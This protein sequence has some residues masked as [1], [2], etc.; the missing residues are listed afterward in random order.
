VQWVGLLPKEY[1]LATVYTAAVCTQTEQPQAA[2]MLIDM[3][4][5]ARAAELRRSG[6]F[7]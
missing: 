4:A 6:G 7:E 5:G 3:L 1:E 2:A